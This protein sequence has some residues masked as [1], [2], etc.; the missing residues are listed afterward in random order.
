MGGRELTSS[1]VLSTSVLA[2]D[3]SQRQAT[4]EPPFCPAPFPFVSLRT[5]AVR[6]DFTRESHLAPHRDTSGVHTRSIRGPTGLLSQEAAPEPGSGRHVFADAFAGVA[7]VS[8]LV[9]F[10][11]IETRDSSC[12]INRKKR[13]NVF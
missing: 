6:P 8:H 3:L 7:G 10:H 13:N 12:K 4:E 11:R 9:H 5:G 1:H 2:R